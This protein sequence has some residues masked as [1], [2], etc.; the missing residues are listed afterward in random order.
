MSESARARI[1]HLV[2]DITAL[3]PKLDSLASLLKLKLGTFTAVDVE[4]HAVDYWRTR[5]L[6]DAVIR[7][8]IFVERNFSHIE[9]LGVLSLCRYT[10]E[11]VVWL[12]L[13]QKDERFSLVYARE[14]LKQ[15]HDLYQDLANH[16]EREIALYRA[17]DEEE[18]VAH[19]RILEAATATPVADA[20]MT[21]RKIIEDM[22]AASDSVD[23][24]L[25][26]NFTIYSDEIKQ[27]G[28]GFQSHIIQTQALPHALDYAERNR[29]SLAKFDEKWGTIIK[30]LKLKLKELKWKA[31]AAYVDMASEYDFIYS[32]TSR[33]LHATPASLST[34]QKSLEDEEAL[35]FLRYVATQFRWII[36]HAEALETRQ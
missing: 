29:D 19:P 14:L 4:Q 32:Y 6:C 30:E 1:S 11:L 21:G 36:N 28:Y 12:K 2:A 22:H 18:K 25:A 27:N 9:T 23:E 34:N 10:F 8:R 3:Q 24:K 16:L 26:L 35:M 5:S 20:K 13:I 15:Q 17:L 33:L 31:R 7:V